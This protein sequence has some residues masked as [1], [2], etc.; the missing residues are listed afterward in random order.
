VK[1]K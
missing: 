1:R